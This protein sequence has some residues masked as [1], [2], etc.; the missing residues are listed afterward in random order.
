MTVQQLLTPEQFNLADPD[1][2]QDPYPFYP[3]LRETRPVLKTSVGG[4]PCWVLSRRADI[5]KV[6]MDPQTYS[7]RHTPLPNMLF[8]DPPEHE[9]M[10]KMV[11]NMF[12][13][14]AVLP[15]AEGIADMADRL[16]DKGLSRGGIDVIADFAGP[17]S[18]ETIGQ[19]LGISGLHVE[20]LRGLSHHF[21]AYV[22]ALQLGIA[23]SEE[24]RLATEELNRFVVELIDTNGYVEGRVLSALAE[25]RRI[26]ELDA[27]GLVNFAILLL[28]AGHSTTTNLI[29]NAVFILTQRPLDCDRLVN[30]DGF[31]DRFLE[32]VL[33]MRPSFHRIH[34]ITTREVEIAGET[35]PAGAIVRLMLASGNRDP[36]FFENPEIFDPDLKRRAHNAFGQG[37]HSCLGNW[38][39]RLEASTAL[40]SLAK[41]T[42]AVQL[43]PARPAQPHVG[44][45]FNE[46]GFD[47]LPI[48][49]TARL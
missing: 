21:V 11:G 26:G 18:I 31:S 4:Q 25:Q 48:V 29:G 43:D 19:L 45:S 46:F 12:A 47:G 15:M 6:L 33:R 49:I 8:S 30:E 13:R 27:D 28:V 41:K 24:A 22:R 1:I 9:R 34:R 40:V 39:A 36:A 44:G 42:A 17:L 20:K 2:Q 38:L 14:L 35:I 7:N 23:P 32:E 3:I 37:I 10:R 16:I 5:V